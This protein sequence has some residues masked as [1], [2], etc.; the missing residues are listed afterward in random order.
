MGCLL[1]GYR[2]FTRFPSSIGTGQTEE[3]PVG[4]R[5]AE[6]I[7]FRCC[8]VRKEAKSGGR[9]SASLG[10]DRSDPTKGTNSHTKKEIKRS[11]PPAILFCFFGS[12]RRSC[13][14]TDIRRKL[15]SPKRQRVPSSMSHSSS[16]TQRHRHRFLFSFV[17]LSNTHTQAHSEQKMALVAFADGV[18]DSFFPA[19]MSSF[20]SSPFGVLL[21][22]ALRLLVGLASDDD[23]IGFH[24]IW[25]ALGRSHFLDDL[26]STLF[27]WN[28]T[29]NNRFFPS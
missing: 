8:I 21:G 19:R 20:L 24:W 11:N 22:V 27:E 14:I 4:Q 17:P 13:L 26:L 3:V 2:V 23:L 16:S 10:L 5:A 9:C 15:S 18:V 1:A 6:S 28:P 7:E 29:S 25:T 12:T